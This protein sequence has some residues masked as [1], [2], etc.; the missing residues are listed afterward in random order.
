M[1]A[2]SDS[3]REYMD[4]CAADSDGGMFWKKLKN[5]TV[6]DRAKCFDKALDCGSNWQQKDLIGNLAY[7][8][9]G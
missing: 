4:M 6:Q 8:L 7:R 2:A 1:R 5:E 9:Y 3:V